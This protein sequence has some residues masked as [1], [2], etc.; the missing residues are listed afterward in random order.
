MALIAN[1]ESNKDVSISVVGVKIL[2]VQH[3]FTTSIPSSAPS[4]WIFDA[5]WP[6]PTAQ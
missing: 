6:I 4:F 2:S 3:I 1:N 5:I